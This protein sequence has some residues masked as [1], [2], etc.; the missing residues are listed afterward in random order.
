MTDVVKM[1]RG[2]PT[3]RRVAAADVPTDQAHSELNPRP[4]QF[5]T[6]LTPIG[7]G[8]D[9]SYLVK[10]RTLISHS[11]LPESSSSTI[12]TQANDLPFAL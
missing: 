6:F 12:A 4:A 5:Q 11:I 10:M 3:P 2:M 9:R 1:R 7:V 8:L